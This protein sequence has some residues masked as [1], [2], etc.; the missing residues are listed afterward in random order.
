MK[1]KTFR[2]GQFTCKGYEKTVGNGYEVGIIFNGKHIFVGNFIHKS[3]ATSWWKTMSKELNG[4][5]NKYWVA[6]NVSKAWYGNF[7]GHYIYNCYYKF[8]DNKF[9]K[10]HT[11]YNKVLKVNF[12]QYKNLRKNW[13]TYDRQNYFKRAA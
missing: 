13:D 11:S 6:Q 5:K 8:L 4:F 9:D 10:Y 3:E 2:F 12:K 1:T 7:I